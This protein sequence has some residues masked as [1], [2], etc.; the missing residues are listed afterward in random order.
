MEFFQVFY[1]VEI[2]FTAV[3]SAYTKI[4]VF[5]GSVDVDLNAILGIGQRTI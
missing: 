3:E 5:F 4:D 1:F 2:F